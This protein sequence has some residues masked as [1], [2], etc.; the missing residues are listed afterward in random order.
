MFAE[1]YYVSN[2]LNVEHGLQVISPMLRTIKIK[3]TLIVIVIKPKSIIYN[4]V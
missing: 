3:N 1:V 2:I 4:K